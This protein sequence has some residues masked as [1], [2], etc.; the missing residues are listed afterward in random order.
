M[1]P[2][3]NRASHLLRLFR[4]APVLD[5][6]S[7]FIGLER[8]DEIGY[9]SV[10]R[11]FKRVSVVWVSN[12]RH[13]P[14]PAREQL[15]KAACSVGYDQYVLTDDDVSF[16]SQSLTNLLAAQ[17]AYEDAVGQSAAVSGFHSILRLYDQEAIERTSTHYGGYHTYQKVSF[18]MWA[19]PAP[20]LEQYT[21]PDDA[22]AIDD[23]YTGMAA[24][25]WGL[26]EWRVC[27]DAPFNAEPR[28]SAGGMGTEP[29]R[30]KALGHSIAR[31]AEDFPEYVSKDSVS[32]KFNFNRMIEMARHKQSNVK[33]GRT[34]R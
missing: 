18:M 33:R 25:R 2:S 27:V 21:Y 8:D 1:I 28:W 12:P 7:T 22:G 10:L 3:R 34:W 16:T 19:V 13:T 29:E 9:R 17:T 4:R 6:P 11:T 5:T 30:V 14:G 15:R 32:T 20:F 31:I 24:L 26:T 23:V